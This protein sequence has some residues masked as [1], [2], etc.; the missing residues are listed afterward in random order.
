MCYELLTPYSLITLS[1][2]RINL[3]RV[4]LELVKNFLDDKEIVNKEMRET[5]NTKLKAK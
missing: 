3:R 1:G 5:E 4:S 2:N